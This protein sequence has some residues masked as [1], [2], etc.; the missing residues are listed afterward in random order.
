MQTLSPKSQVLISLG[1]CLGMGCTTVLTERGSYQFFARPDAADAWSPKIAAWQH[2]E[3]LDD[4][5]APG[6][7]AAESREVLSEGVHESEVVRVLAGVD[8]E[9]S[10]D[11]LRAKYFRFRADR[12]REMAAGFVDWIQGQALEHYVADGEI[13]HW[14]TFEETLRENGDDCD[15]LE[16]LVYHGLRDLGFSEREVYRAIVYRPSDGQHHM[17]TLW[18]EDPDDPWVLDPT[19]AMTGSMLLMSELPSWVPLK[20]FSETAEYTVRRER[21]PATSL[22][23]TLR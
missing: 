20:L 14:A 1:L 17:V 2:R 9:D 8:A 15:G 22:A 6:R 12:R 11:D 3:D 16:L 5:A 21:A 13:D 10:V 4:G 23:S 19:G 18:F 7:V